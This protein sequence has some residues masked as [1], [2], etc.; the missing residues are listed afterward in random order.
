MKTILLE[1]AKSDLR[2]I[3]RRAVVDR[4]E[5]VI[6]SDDGAVVVLDQQEWA[7]IQAKL[8][9]L[10]LNEL[11]R[12]DGVHRQSG[13]R[14][15]IDEIFFQ[16]LDWL[17]GGTQKRNLGIAAIEANWDRSRFRQLCVPLLI[18]SA[19]Y[20]IAESDQAD[21]AN[22]LN[23]LYRMIRLLFSYKRLPPKYHNVLQRFATRNL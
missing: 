23:N 10:R 19:I 8:P 13:G 1:Q 20:L 4:D 15:M 6:A 17:S 2:G 5:T 12:H 14:Q 9:P 11:E 16:S 7:H 22:E 3:I 18:N 21:S